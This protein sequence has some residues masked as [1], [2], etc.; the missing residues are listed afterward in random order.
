[1]PLPDL[2]LAVSELQAQ[3]GLWTSMPVRPA[4]ITASL[5]QISTNT[6]G[7][8][9][10][11]SQLPLT[12]VASA[13]YPETEPLV[14]PSRRCRSLAMLTASSQGCGRARDGEAVRAPKGASSQTWGR[15]R[16]FQ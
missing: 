14:H 8:P 9:M 7:G 10:L 13:S 6:R 5:W 15:R 4:E 11:R 16:G 3:G 1:M 12:S 2:A